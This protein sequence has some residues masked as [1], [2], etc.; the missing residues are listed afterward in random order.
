[1]IK[2]ISRLS[3]LLAMLPLAAL[4]T[5][6]SQAEFLPAALPEPVAAAIAAG[7]CEQLI[8]LNKHYHAE[9]MAAE[10]AV[11]IA[12]LE[13]AIL[14]L[15]ACGN[16]SATLVRVEP[17]RGVDFFNPQSPLGSSSLGR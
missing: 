5:G 1:M 15:P 11:V 10:R 8:A 17:L 16:V 7:D 3:R 14:A 6:L 4:T 2:L 12:A 9:P 13:E